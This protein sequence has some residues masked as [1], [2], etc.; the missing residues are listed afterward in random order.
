MNIEDLTH[1]LNDV[2]TEQYPRGYLGMSGV[3]EPCY[4][5]HQFDHYRAY[6]VM[7]SARMDRLLSFGHKAEVFM[8][9]DLEA[10]GFV[11]VSNQSELVGF[12]GHWKGHDDGVMLYKDKMYL[13]EFKT[14]KDSSFKV[15]KKNGVAKAKPTHLHQVNTYM[16]KHNL[17]ECVYLAYNKDTS[18]YYLELIVFDEEM[19]NDDEHKMESLVLATEL[20]PRI[21]NG[22]SS[23]FECKLCDARRVCWE[24]TPVKENCRTCKAVNVEE[25]G[26]WSCGFYEKELDDSDQMIGCLHYEKSEIMKWVD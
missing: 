20:Y 18:E 16:G 23:W 6:S 4:R 15:L 21:G 7:R 25:D 8:I 2:T 10:K 26:K 3:G 12:A 24:L 1:E 14:H 11:F 19:F 22:S 13:A 17:E 5:K 9:A